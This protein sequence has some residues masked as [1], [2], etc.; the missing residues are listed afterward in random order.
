MSAKQLQVIALV[1]LRTEE[2]GRDTST[3]STCNT[4]TV[5]LHTQNSLVLYEYEYCTV[6]RSNGSL[7]V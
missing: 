5:A 6:Y 2:D 7:Q 4:S 1:V 3:T